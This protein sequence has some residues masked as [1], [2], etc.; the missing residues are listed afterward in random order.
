MKTEKALK[1]KKI[2]FTAVSVAAVIFAIALITVFAPKQ[3]I[4][5]ATTEKG[6]EVTKAE[7]TMREIEK[8]DD[9]K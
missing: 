5:R 7:Q 1:T 4:A 6:A 2:T 8:S 3:T 9:K